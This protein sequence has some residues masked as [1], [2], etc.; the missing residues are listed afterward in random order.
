M[1]QSQPLV[2]DEDGVHAGTVWDNLSCGAKLFVHRG[3]PTDLQHIC[4][5]DDPHGL[6]L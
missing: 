1:L 6:Q 5:A 3:W 4:D 2:G